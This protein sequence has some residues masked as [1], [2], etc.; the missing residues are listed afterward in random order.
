ML[1]LISLFCIIHVQVV[2]RFKMKFNYVVSSIILAMAGV[3][4]SGMAMANSG[5]INFSGNITASTCEVNGGAGAVI[6]VPMGTVPA[7]SLANQGDRAGM[8]DFTISLTQC[9]GGSTEAAVRFEGP[10]VDSATGV[11]N[12][13]NA[14]TAQNVDIALFMKE[15]DARVAMGAAE[16]G[17]GEY[18]NIV[19]G[20]ADLKYSAYYFKNDALAVVPGTA[21]STANYLISYK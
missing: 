15:T 16:P 13:D 3:G 9:S 12:L 20:A 21:N 2:E 7:S 1:E 8:S 14:S 19:N 4:S 11:L 18:V 5:Q 10:N 17:A 6:A